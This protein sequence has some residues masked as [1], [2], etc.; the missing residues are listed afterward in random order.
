MIEGFAILEDFILLRII[1]YG[2]VIHKVLLSKIAMANGNF[3]T[4]HILKRVNPNTTFYSYY[5]F[6]KAMR[7]D[8][9]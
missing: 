6:P 5:F 4:S 9:V 2:I 3:R 7:C 1:F 8:F